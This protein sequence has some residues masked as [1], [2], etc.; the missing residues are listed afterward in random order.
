MGKLA[1]V[2]NLLLLIATVGMLDDWFTHNGLDAVVDFLSSGSPDANAV[3]L[4]VATP[5]VSL[6]ALW[7][8]RSSSRSPSASA[9]G[10]GSV[11]PPRSSSVEFRR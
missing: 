3:L 2:L 6:R 7:G 10:T 1:V 5:V 9:V 8:A 4:G 11:Q